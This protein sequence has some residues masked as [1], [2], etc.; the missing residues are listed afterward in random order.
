MVEGVERDEGR[1]K[2]SGPRERGKKGRVGREIY[3]RALE[4]QGRW[5]KS[6]TEWC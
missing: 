1:S 6:E 4:R 5:A 3:W 2:G